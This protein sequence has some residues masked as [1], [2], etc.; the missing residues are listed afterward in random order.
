MYVGG[1]GWVKVNKAL[2]RLTRGAL[3]V[4]LLMSMTEAFSVFIY[5]LIKLLY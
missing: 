1:V 5:T 2:I 4:P 3:F